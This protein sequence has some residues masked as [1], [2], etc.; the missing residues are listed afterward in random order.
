MEK[1]PLDIRLACNAFR[2][3]FNDTH[4]SWFWLDAGP[5]LV[6]EQCMTRFSR[7]SRDD[8][9]LG[10]APQKVRS[11]PGSVLADFVEKPVDFA[12]SDTDM[13]V[14]ES[15]VDQPK[16]DETVGKFEGCVI[17]KLPLDV[18]SP[19]TTISE[20][21][22]I[23]KLHGITI[24]KRDSKEMQALKLVTA[25]PDKSKERM[26]KL[27]EAKRV[28]EKDKQ[29]ED[30]ASLRKEVLMA[31][32]PPRPPTQDKIDAIISRCCDM[33]DPSSFQE[34]GCSICGQ[35]TILT[36]LGDI[37][38]LQELD[39]PV[40]ANDSGKACGACLTAL[41]KKVLPVKSLANGLW[42]A[43]VRHSQCVV[44]VSSG[45]VKMIANCIMWA[46]PTVKV[47]KRLPPSKDELSEV[48]A[49]VAHADYADL[50]IAWDNLESYPLS[51]VPVVVDYRKIDTSA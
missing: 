14:F 20:M 15:Y 30:V 8:L 12:P 31:T 38:I 27:R 29:K 37:K 13:F 35:L 2:H 24:S 19:M 1:Y 5:G 10:G 49:F 28:A 16:L 22:A 42:V 18:L 25:K 9:L 48:L 26:R 39:G 4:R 33:M 36:E 34:D 6:Q 21:T 40:L 3:L 23:S 32:F 46:L 11:V 41:R 51:G 45:R 43:R 50:T 44:R 7:P 17:A 47:Y